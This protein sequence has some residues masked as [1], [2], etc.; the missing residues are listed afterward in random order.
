MLVRSAGSFR[1]VKKVCRQ[2]QLIVRDREQAAPFM[3]DDFERPTV[4]ERDY[5]SLHRHRL[6]EHQTKGL[7]K[8]RQGEHITGGEE[9]GH[10]LRG[11]G[12]DHVLR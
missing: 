7:L 12:E 6:E 2:S 11:A 1:S 10:S 3:L 5:R 4:G 9:G 8:G